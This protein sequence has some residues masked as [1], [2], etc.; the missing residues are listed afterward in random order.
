MEQ[1]QPVAPG[2]NLAD[3]QAQNA[4]AAALNANARRNNLKTA[5][6]HIDDTNSP[7]SRTGTPN[8]YAGQMLYHSLDE[9]HLQQ[10]LAGFGLGAP[11]NGHPHSP[12]NGE[13]MPQTQ[14]EL[15]AINSGLKTRVDEL[16]VI[17]DLIQRRLQ[18]YETYG[19][20]PAP[21]TGLEGSHEAEVQLRAQIDALAASEAQLRSQL[22][23]SHRRENNLKRRLDEMELELNEVRQHLV[24]HE[25]D[26]DAK[27]PRL[28]DT[29]ALDAD[30]GLKPETMADLASAAG[31]VADGPSEPSA[32]ISTDVT[33]E[34]HADVTIESH[35]EPPVEAPID[36]PI[37]A[38]VH[39][40]AEPTAEAPAEPSAELTAEQAVE[41]LADQPAEVPVEAPATEAQAEAPLMDEALE[42]TVS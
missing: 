1:N 31:A 27:R 2:G 26:R 20:A 39:G 7:I 33:I 35:A 8:T 37:E 15:L 23:E 3:I 10:P 29:L 24:I 41:T 13:G 18:H 12:L 5:N 38:A 9:H 42:S 36:V 16:E 34:S 32:E 17:N 11:G 28:E 14:E 4:A 21:P 6:G 22:E 30:G 25:G 19:N 40:P